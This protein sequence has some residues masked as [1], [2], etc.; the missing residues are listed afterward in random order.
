M[1]V[2]RLFFAWLI[3]LITLI[4]LS[5]ARPTPAPL[6]PISR[7]LPPGTFWIGTM[8]TPDRATNTATLRVIG[9]RDANANVQLNNKFG[10]YHLTIALRDNKLAVIDVTASGLPD[11]PNTP[12]FDNIDCSSDLPETG[13]AKKLHFTGTWDITRNSQTHQGMPNFEFEV[14]PTSVKKPGSGVPDP[15]RPHKAISAYLPPDSHWTGVWTTN[16]GVVMDA[17]ATIS[18]GDDKQH[19]TMDLSAG[20]RNVSLQVAIKDGL[21]SVVSAQANSGTYSNLGIVSNFPDLSSQRWVH[22]W[23]QWNYVDADGTD[24]GQ[25]SPYFDLRLTSP[26]PTAGADEKPGDTSN[27]TI[28]NQRPAGKDALTARA[29]DGPGKWVDLLPLTDPAKDSVVGQWRRSGKSLVSEAKDSQV[30]DFPYNVPDEYDLR[31]LFIR[32]KGNDPVEILGSGPSGPFS[33]VIGGHEGTLEY[34][35]FQ[36]VSGADADSNSSTVRAD[37]FISNNHVCIVTICVRKDHLQGLLNEGTVSSM[38]DVDKVSADTPSG[39]PKS[40]TGVKVSN[41]VIFIGSARVTVVTGQGTP[42]RDGT[43]H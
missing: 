39:F 43:G 10:M 3:T 13:P 40:T 30:I 15:S 35:G 18:A 14:D 28:T 38:I 8:T 27:D 11:D 29:P 12:H 2:R 42:L 17:E 9:F 7:Y 41:D 34:A 24:R 21:L 37:H 23:G 36:N 31:I 33:F 20:D 22:F 1:M 32:R 6:P 26:P 5:V 4:N 25:L 19:A 16:D